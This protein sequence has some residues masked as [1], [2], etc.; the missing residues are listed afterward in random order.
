[1][2]PFL[3]EIDFIFTSSFKTFT[4][5]NEA[6]TSSKKTVFLLCC[7]YKES[8]NVRLKIFIFTEGN[9]FKELIVM[10]SKRI[11]PLLFSFNIFS[12]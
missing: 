6:L 5:D 7:V 11:S 10:E 3:A 8:I 9:S 12:I 1:M 2:C 4:I